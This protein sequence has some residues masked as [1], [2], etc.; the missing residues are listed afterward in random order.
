MDGEQSARP[1]TWIGTSR[2]E[3]KGFPPPVRRDMGKALYAAQRGE[4]DPAAKPLRGFAWARVMEI[5]DLHDTNTYRAVYTAQFGEA[6][7][8]LHAFQKKSKRGI[9]TPAREIELVRRRL[10]DAERLHRQRQP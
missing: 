4:T 5:V 10:A 7:Y 3:L 1:V 8:V 2:R 6:I 9:A